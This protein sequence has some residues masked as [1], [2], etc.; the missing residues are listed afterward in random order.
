MAVIFFACSSV[1]FLLAVIVYCTRTLSS[2][3]KQ[4][5]SQ[6]NRPLMKNQHTEEPGWTGAYTTP[7]R[8]PSSY[9]ALSTSGPVTT[10]RLRQGVEINVRHEPDNHGAL[11]GRKLQ[12]DTTFQ[13]AETHNISNRTWLRLED[14]GWISQSSKGKLLA[15][16]VNAS[17][18]MPHTSMPHTSMPHT[19]MPHTSSVTDGL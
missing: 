14:G 16:A 6:L 2:L 9:P 8:P 7:P 1:I 10:Y 13:V 4:S 18:A 17:T 11:T 15:D 12:Q 19:S 5:N 3:P